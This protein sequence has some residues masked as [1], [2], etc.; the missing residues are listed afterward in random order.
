M[1]ALRVPKQIDGLGDPGVC[2]QIA[3]DP[4]PWSMHFGKPRSLPAHL[5]GF[6]ASAVLWGVHGTIGND[7]G[8]LL[9]PYE[10]PHSHCLDHP[11]YVLLTF[12]ESAGATLEHSYDG[13][14][15]QVFCKLSLYPLFREER[16]LPRDTTLLQSNLTRFTLSF[17]NPD[18]RTPYK[19][20]GAQF[21]F[22]LNFVSPLP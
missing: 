14:C 1:I 2:V 20:H 8:A 6:P 5:M 12:S 10:A 15:R 11:D 22:S 16:M 13:E 9:P 17:W 3:S 18:L 19:F 4:E 21:S 7:E